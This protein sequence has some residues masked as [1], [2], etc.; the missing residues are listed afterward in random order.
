MD[1]NMNFGNYGMYRSMFGG[2]KGGFGRH[3]YLWKNW[4]IQYVSESHECL[5]LVSVTGK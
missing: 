3:C 2:G 4:Y 1:M 5:E